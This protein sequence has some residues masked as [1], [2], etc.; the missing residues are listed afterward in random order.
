MKGF[1]L[2]E[3]SIVLLVA[4]LLAVSVILGQSLVRQ[5]QIQSV[6][7]DINSFRSAIRN[8][9][10][11]YKDL[12]GDMSDATAYWAAT[13]NGDGDGQIEA[14]EDL[15]AWQQLNLANLIQGG[16]T[17]TDAGVPDMQVGINIPK[18]KVTKGG[19][20]PVYGVIGNHTGNFIAFGSE[21]ANSVLG[22]IVTVEEARNIDAKIDD[23]LAA[24]GEV[25]TVDGS[26]V[27]AGT[28]VAG[29]PLAYTANNETIAC[30]MRFMI[31]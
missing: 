5:S 12:P 27:V 26:D 10:D 20:L 7:T 22:S 18:S 8:F 4:G 13:A 29:A 1:T 11:Q 17:G 9:E 16:Y 19:Y 23:G 30:S 14:A 31:N 6:I 15:R 3:L 2:I 21:N 25:M 24:F 28:C